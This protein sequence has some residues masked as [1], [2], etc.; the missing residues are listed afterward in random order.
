[1]GGR[2]FGG[3]AGRTKSSVLR[4]QSAAEDCNSSQIRYMLSKSSAP[5][6][7]DVTVHNSD[8]YQLSHVIAQLRYMYVGTVLS[9]GFTCYCRFA[10][11]NMNKKILCS[12][13]Y[14][15][16]CARWKKNNGKCA[17]AF[18]FKGWV[19][20]IGNIQLW[21]AIWQVLLESH[22]RNQRGI[23]GEFSFNQQ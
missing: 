16:M 17:R 21:K 18:V 15:E 11:G 4:T 5:E 9:C 19:T 20:S 23:K 2:A 14:Y 8:I 13:L 22:L 7:S 12:L 1:M 3:G 10:L 6:A